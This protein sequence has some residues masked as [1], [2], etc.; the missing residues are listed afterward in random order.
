VRLA[1]SPLQRCKSRHQDIGI[2]PRWS[3]QDLET[4]DYRR[5]LDGFEALEQSHRAVQ[6]FG[7]SLYLQHNRSNPS[8]FHPLTS[9]LTLMLQRLTASQ[10][11]SC[12]FQLGFGRKIGRYITEL[13][14]TDIHENKPHNPVNLV[15]ALPLLSNLHTVATPRMNDFA[16]MV[17]NVTEQ[18]EGLGAHRQ[19]PEV[20]FATD[21]LYELFASVASLVVD[22]EECD[23]RLFDILATKSPQSRQLVL[24]DSAEALPERLIDF[25]LAA[26]QS[27]PQLEELILVIHEDFRLI[28]METVRRFVLPPACCLRR[29]SVTT[30]GGD[31]APFYELVGKLS[32]ILRSLS[33]DFNDEHYRSSNYEFPHDIHF[34]QLE[35]LVVTAAS[36]TDLD[37][38]VSTLVPA[39]FPG[40]RRL[41]L[42]TGH[43][44]GEHSG[45]PPQEATID[46]MTSTFAASS[47]SRLLEILADVVAVDVSSFRIGDGRLPAT[48]QP[49]R[50]RRSLIPPSIVRDPGTTRI[51]AIYSETRHDDFPLYKNQEI[52]PLLDRM[53]D[54]A[55]EALQTTDYVQLTRIA[56]ALQPCELLRI[57]RDS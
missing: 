32:P 14:L 9:L 43:A 1:R 48:N 3:G 56:Q 20:A 39:S 2:S 13:D 15:A 31:P 17:A 46:R 42:R 10:I 37:K 8:G 49:G 24:H 19:G 50:T 38:V 53:R 51:E 26:I 33:L 36:P 45:E 18:E 28:D 23:D 29:L 21:A 47:R 5:P 12:K 16:D 6:V 44:V 57:E 35:T 30:D 11:A 40:L 55:D 22:T 27:C 54:M 7:A 41:E 34:P 4:Y 25:A 52:D